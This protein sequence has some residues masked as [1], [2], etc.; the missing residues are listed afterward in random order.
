[1]KGF[2][3][4]DQTRIKKYSVI[5]DLLSDLNEYNFKSMI[6]AKLNK[7]G[8]IIKVVRNKYKFVFVGKC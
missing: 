7:E 2:K 5:F 8:Y 6:E 4:L 3:M 1:M